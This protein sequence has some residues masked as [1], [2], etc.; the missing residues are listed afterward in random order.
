MNWPYLL[1]VFF[2]TLRLRSGQAFHPTDEGLSVGTPALKPCPDT[3]PW[4]LDC[5]GVSC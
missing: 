5:M 1:L 3:K 4:F 2:G